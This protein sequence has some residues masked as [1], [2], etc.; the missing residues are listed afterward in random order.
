LKP[1]YPAAVI[2]DN[3]RGQTTTAILLHLRNHHIIPIQLPANFTDKLQFLD[4]AV[5]KPIKNNLKSKFQ[6]WYTQE[7]TKQLQ[8]TLLSQIK[9]KSSSASWIMAEWLGRKL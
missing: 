9:V 2:F 8:M 6:K 5:N 1:T 7:V 3:F 4:S